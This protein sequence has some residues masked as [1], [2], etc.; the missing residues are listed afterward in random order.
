[1]F[2]RFLMGLALL[3]ALQSMPAVADEGHSHDAAPA[4]PTGSALPRFAATSTRFEMV[5]VVNGKEVTLYLDR[6]EDN[7]PVKGATIDLD[8]GGAKVALKE[9]EDGE[10]EGEM[11]RALKP[12][13][14]P[15]T[16]T[17]VA[18]GETDLLIGELDMHADDHADEAHTHGSREYAAW[19][20]GAAAAALMLAWLGRRSFRIRRVGGAA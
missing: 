11:A 5:G 8:V 18:D 6:F 13:V 14:T 3:A 2:T 4:A 7:A 15:I 19:G 1:M 10:F 17:V 16:A 12:G 20:I 9:H